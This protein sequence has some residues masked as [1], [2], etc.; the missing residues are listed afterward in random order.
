MRQRVEKQE[1]G[2][3]VPASRRLGLQGKKKA[4]RTERRAYSLDG[5]SWKKILHLLSSALRR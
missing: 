2:I 4:Q 3:N 5:T 1:L